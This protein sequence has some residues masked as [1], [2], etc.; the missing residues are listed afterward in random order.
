MQ[1][2]TIRRAAALAGA[3]SVAAAISIVGSTGAQADAPACGNVGISHSLDGG[4]TWLTDSRMDNA[5]P[6]PSTV[7]VKLSQTPAAGCSYDVSLASYSAEG[8]D[9]GDSGTQAF[10]GWDTTTLSA[11]TPQATLTVPTPKCFGQI[12]LYGNNTKYDGVGGALPHYPDS[13]TPNNLITAWNGG[14]ECASTPPTTPPPSSPA[15]PTTP[16]APT[17]SASPTTSATPSASS[18]AS[19]SAAPTK[20]A[21]PTPS[22]KATN[23]APP[24]GTPSVKPVSTA[25]AAHLAET[26]GNGTQTAVIAGAAVVLVALGSGAVV[27]TRRRKGGHT[28]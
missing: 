9:W 25:P 21:S 26:G 3:V 28:A 8:P 20:S 13:V 7:E 6:V 14:S 12:D 23:A 10:L 18:S 4:Q 15:A 11:G 1:K 16:A 22:V 19:P 24:T 2:T 17:S 27:I 5:S